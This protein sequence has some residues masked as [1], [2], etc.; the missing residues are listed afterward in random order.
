MKRS[1][2]MKFLAKVSS[3]VVAVGMIFL[4]LSYMAEHGLTLKQAQVEAGESI[5]HAAQKQI[6]RNS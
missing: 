6:E 1:Q 4:S 3:M 5:K 2:K